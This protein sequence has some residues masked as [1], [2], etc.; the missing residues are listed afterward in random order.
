MTQ[1]GDIE[2]NNGH[3]RMLVKSNGRLLIDGKSIIPIYE[4]KVKALFDA[5][6]DIP[7]A[8][9][10]TDIRRHNYSHLPSNPWRNNGHKKF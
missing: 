4:S 1:T 9:F 2:L 7:S 8:Y 3:N 6:K 5:G 10:S